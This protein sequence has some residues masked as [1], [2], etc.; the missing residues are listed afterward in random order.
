MS[1]C[2]L[3][4]LDTKVI[5]NLCNIFTHLLLNLQMHPQGLMPTMGKELVQYFSTVWTAGEQSFLYWSVTTTIMLNG[6]DTLGHVPIQRMLGFTLAL[7]VSWLINLSSCLG[8]DIIIDLVTDAT[9]CVHG[10][11]RLVEGL[12]STEGR[13][14]VCMSGRWTGI[15][16]SSWNYQDAFVVCRQLGYPATGKLEKYS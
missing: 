1:S 12:V 13:V 2:S 16:D 3:Y 4:S 5:G 6:L 15:C 8:Y 7:N 9:S 14:E 11:V 10:D